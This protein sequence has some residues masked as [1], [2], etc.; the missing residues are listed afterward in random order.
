MSQSDVARI[1]QASEHLDAARKKM[2]WHDGAGCLADLDEHDKL[3][4]RPAMA[5]TNADSYAAM[6]RA[7]C[8]ML[9]GQCEAGRT[10]YRKAFTAMQGANG[11]PEQTEKVTDAMVGMYCHGTNLSPRDQVLQ[12][13]A[14]L[15]AGAWMTTKP[16]ATCLAAYKTVMKNR[17]TVVPRDDDDVMVKDPVSFLLVAAP[18]CLARAGDCEAAWKVYQEIAAEKFKGQIILS[19]PDILRSS[20]ESITPKCKGK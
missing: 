4:P 2:A 13:R 10:L 12:A 20:F 19:K 1:L 18:N 9:A 15:Q 5:S 11:S 14:E 7:Q 8:L 6:L 17:T 3:D 16:A